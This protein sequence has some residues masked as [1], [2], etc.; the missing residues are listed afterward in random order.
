MKPENF[1]KLAPGRT[2]WMPEGFWAFV[3]D[4][5]PPNI[6]WNSNLVTALSAA[7]RAVGEL[8]GLGRNLPNPHLLINPF[9]RREAVLSSRIEGTRASLSDIYAYE[10]GQLRFWEYMDTE[11]VREVVNY[12]RALEYGLQRM[13][14]LPLSL[15]LIR[16][17][18]GILMEG[19]RGSSR[20]PGEFRRVQNWIGPPGCSAAEA[21][22]VPPPVSEMHQALDKLERFLHDEQ[23]LPP[24]IKAAL[25]HYQFEAIHPFLDGN[26][27][28]GRMLIILLLCNWGILPQPLLYLS[29][30]FAM[31]R[32]T[33]YECLQSVSTRGDWNKWL[34]FFLQGVESQARDAIL[35]AKRLQDL[36]RNYH[37]RL[38]RTRV[39]ATTLR[40]VDFLFEYPVVSVPQLARYLDITFTA[41]SKHV[42]ALEEKGILRRVGERKR[43]QLYVAVEILAAIEHP[44][45]SDSSSAR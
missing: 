38:A 5:L 30:Y 26:G 17:L 20:A 29:A 1:T 23:G 19:V 28:M 25:A 10:V 3:P 40:L 33:Y 16:E 31:Y 35:R 39:P 34:L 2:I 4:P 21:H 8:A 12:I 22:F 37:Q 11:D 42:K 7:D 13:N 45:T 36:Q 41:T 32:D 44:L 15:R 24:L 9:I 43:N 18:H 27:R 6:D 14:D